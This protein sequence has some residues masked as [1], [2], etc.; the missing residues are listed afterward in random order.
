[1][2]SN[3][4]VSLHDEAPLEVNRGG[5]KAWRKAVFGTPA[6]GDREAFVLGT[7]AGIVANI[8]KVLV[9]HRVLGE[10]HD[11]VTK[12]AVVV[13][14]QLQLETAL[15]RDGDRPPASM[16]HSRRHWTWCSGEEIP[17]C[18]LKNPMSKIEKSG[19]HEKP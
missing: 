16:R 1:M 4:I 18:I 8:A 6:R 19:E 15:S 5:S 11:I 3:A 9:V 12:Q 17:V 14:G 7:M 10:V 2:S 13:T